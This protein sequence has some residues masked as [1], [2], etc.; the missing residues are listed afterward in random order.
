[1]CV[2]PKLD[3]VKST[4]KSKERHVG[5][6][7]HRDELLLTSLSLTIKGGNWHKRLQPLGQVELFDGEAHIDV[8]V[9]L[10]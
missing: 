1:M 10:D 6:L 9:E 4:R 2:E 8:V 3:L 7:D 5:A